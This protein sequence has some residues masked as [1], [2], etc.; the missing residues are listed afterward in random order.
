M[1]GL[2]GANLELENYYDLA[3]NMSREKVAK[4]YTDEY[5]VNCCDLKTT[6]N[7]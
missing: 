7:E 3:L 1:K 5:S 4:E 6:K 2:R